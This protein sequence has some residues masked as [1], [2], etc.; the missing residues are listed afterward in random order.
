MKNT[1]FV[2]YSNQRDDRYK[3][4]TV[5]SED[6][7]GNRYV[8][9][10]PLT[11]AAKVHIEQIAE[12]G[13]QLEDIAADTKFTFNKCDAKDGVVHCEYI[14]GTAFSSVIGQK[15]MSGDEEGALKLAQEYCG[16]LYKVA[17]VPFAETE[18]F[19]KVFGRP[20]FDRAHMSWAVTDV[21]RARL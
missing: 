1:I 5:I 16:E 15:V 11:K 13:K 9:K 4:K 3:I 12:Y 18:A 21:V 7:T 2:K 6:E 20:M 10:Y 17:T 8:E 14:T 19:A